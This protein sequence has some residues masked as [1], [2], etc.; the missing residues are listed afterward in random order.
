MHPIHVVPHFPWTENLGLC[1]KMDWLMSEAPD[2][3]CLRRMCPAKICCSEMATPVPWVWCGRSDRKSCSRTMRYGCKCDVCDSSNENN[4]NNMLT[5]YLVNPVKY[6][7]PFDIQHIP[8]SAP[9]THKKFIECQYIIHFDKTE[10]IALYNL[11][12]Y[13]PINKFPIACECVAVWM[14]TI[15]KESS[16]EMRSDEHTYTHP[17]TNRIRCNRSYSRRV[18]YMRIQWTKDFRQ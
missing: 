16:V 13:F 6:S 18:E 9:H 11:I 12:N 14:W 1:G 4:N 2:F 8:L 10:F 15:E 17:S 3:E 7:S 5:M